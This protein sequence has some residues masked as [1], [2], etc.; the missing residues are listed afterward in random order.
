MGDLLGHRYSHATG[1]RAIEAVQERV[2]AFRERCLKPRH[3]V[4]YLFGRV[5]CEGPAPEAGI[6][7]E[8]VQLALGP[9]K[10]GGAK[11]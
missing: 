5:V 7:K 2:Q 3:A 11:S 8:S 6:R 9:P 1:S 4:I 10:R